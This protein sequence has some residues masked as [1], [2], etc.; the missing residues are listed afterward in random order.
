MVDFFNPAGRGGV[1]VLGNFRTA[2]A[3]A[4]MD[5]L[6]QSQAP[7]LEPEFQQLLSVDPARAKQLIE[8]TGAQDAMRL[9]AML[10]DAK[11]AKNFLAQDNL[12]GAAGVLMNRLQLLE[13]RD[14]SQ[15]AEVF[16]DIV[17]GQP[18]QAIGK[19]DS[20]LSLFDPELK[21]VRQQAKTVSVAKVDPESG[22]IFHTVVNPNDNSVQ[23]IDV[24]GAFAQTPSEKR[25]GEV[26]KETK[27]NAI[28]AGI[29][30]C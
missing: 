26:N 1:D 13:G 11:V 21:N 16:R 8:V 27:K 3:D 12:Q 9:N 19:I 7:Q 24:P 23:R 5:N 30:S 10:Q 2:Q 6:S 4:L 28:Q 15:T 25:T 14:N 20:F 22:Q 17:N 29:R 18:D